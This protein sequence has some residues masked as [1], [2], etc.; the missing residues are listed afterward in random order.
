MELEHKSISTKGI[1]GVDR[2]QGIV[3]AIV[4]VTGIEDNV[5]DIILPGAFTKSMLTRTPKGVWSHDWKIPVSRTLEMKELQP[6]DPE[7][8]E[9]LAN[10]APWP[11]EAG[12]LKVKTQFNMNTPEGKSAFE[13]VIFFEDEQEWSIGYQVPREAAFRDSKGIRHIKELNWYEYSPVLFGAMSNARSVKDLAHDQLM[14]IKSILGEDALKDELAS[15]VE[16]DPDA[17]IAKAAGVEPDDIR[18]L[19][20]MQ[21]DIDKVLSRYATQLED[22][23][24]ED[25]DIADEEKTIEQILSSLETKGYDATEVRQAIGSM[26]LARD[27]NSP[28]DVIRSADDVLTIIERDVSTN[29]SYTVDLAALADAVATIT[30]EVARPAFAADIDFEMFDDDDYEGLDDIDLIEDNTDEDDFEEVD[31]A[32]T[33]EKFLQLSDTEYKAFLLDL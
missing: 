2:E 32:G 29:D 23:D 27:E 12:A 7:L 13:N 16:E 26:T 28:V 18:R 17:D 30:D 31:E 20:S 5:K 4:S 19:I 6:G 11:K 33:Q 21:D 8:P 15:I 14:S 1:V 24:I 3:S 22:E 10:G 9:T 25:E